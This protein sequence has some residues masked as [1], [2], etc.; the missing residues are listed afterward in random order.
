MPCSVD[1]INIFRKSA[2]VPAIVEQVIE[3]DPLPKAIWMQQGIVNES[4][5]TVARERGIFVVMNRC[6]KVD[7]ANFLHQ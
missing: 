2:D 4:A 1:L 7:H 5:A 3:M 6:I